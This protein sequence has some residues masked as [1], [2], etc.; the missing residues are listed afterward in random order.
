MNIANFKSDDFITRNEPSA[1][2][3]GSHTLMWGTVEEPHRDRSYI[4]D[5]FKLIG[6]ENGFIV[7]RRDDT[8]IIKD[9]ALI[10]PVDKWAEGW[11]H[12][13]TRLVDQ[14]RRDD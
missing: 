3:G 12:Y 6:V 5:L 1:P 8:S 2:F 14:A 10:L 7:L 13:P 4:D 11:V 9:K